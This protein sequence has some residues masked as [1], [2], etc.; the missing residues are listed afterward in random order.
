V[1]ALLGLLAAAPQAPAVEWLHEIYHGGR[2]GACRLARVSRPLHGQ[3]IDHT[4]NHGVDRRIWSEALCQ[5]RDL[6]VYLPPGYDPAQRYPL[7]LWLHGFGQDEESFLDG[8]VQDMDAAMACGQLPPMIVA[9]P[10]GSISG[11]PCMMTAGSFYINSPAGRFEDYV[12]EDVWNFLVLNYPIRPE[13]EAH[14]LAGVSMGGGGAYTLAIKHRDR[15][16]VVLG[17]FPPLNSRWVDCH[18]RYMAD[19]DPNCWGWRTDF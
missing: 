13:R 4:H 14:V 9:A 2:L 6:Y 18:G 7:V 16:A 15:F 12:M 10:D 8:I 19:F 3:L 11:H 17:I 5:R 1:A